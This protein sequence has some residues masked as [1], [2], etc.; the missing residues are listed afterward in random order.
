MRKVAA[1]TSL[2]CLS[3]FLVA[4]QS[5]TFVIQKNRSN[6]EIQTQVKTDTANSIPQPVFNRGNS[7][8]SDLMFNSPNF[9]Q[10]QRDTVST[11]VAIEE[12]QQRL[13]SF[14]PNSRT[15]ANVLVEL[16]LKT[17]TPTGNE[18]WP[19]KSLRLS[20]AVIQK[21]RTLSAGDKVVVTKLRFTSCGNPP[22]VVNLIVPYIIFLQ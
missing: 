19:Q 17:I 4:Q 14:A 3:E 13:Y 18:D 10:R 8:K 15:G 2:F 21:I 1:L 11:E 20:E 6:T 5:D 12:I 16:V 22:E 9:D 7:F